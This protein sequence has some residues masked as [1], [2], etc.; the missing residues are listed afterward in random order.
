MSSDDNFLNDFASFDP[1]YVD[2]VFAALCSY[3][4]TAS[5]IIRGIFGYEAV[6][7]RYAADYEAIT[8]LACQQTH[9]V[10][11]TTGKVLGAEEE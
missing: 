4:K 3:G 6:D 1:V 9:L 8:C 10:N 2:G 11:P 5:R 7:S